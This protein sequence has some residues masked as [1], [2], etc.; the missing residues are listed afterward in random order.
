MV[1]VFPVHLREKCF[2]QKI[3]IITEKVSK[4]IEAKVHESFRINELDVR[5]RKEALDLYNT[6]LFE[7]T[8]GNRK[9]YQRP[10][11]ETMIMNF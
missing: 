5:K 9:D 6:T 3:K 2:A 11:L 10:K 7:L 1:L 8:N 4:R